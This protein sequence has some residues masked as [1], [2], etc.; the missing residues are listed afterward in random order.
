MRET[1]TKIMGENWRT[2]GAV[3]PK[4][5]MR[6]TVK[7]TDSDG[8][9]R[10]RLHHTDVVTIRANGDV[11]LDSGGWKTP[12][13]KERINACVPGLIRVFQN[14]GLWFVTKEGQS[15]IPFFDGMTIKKGKLPKVKIDASKKE[16]ALRK[17]IKKYAARIHKL[18][19]VPEPDSGDC[20]LCLMET[21]KGQT[22]GESGGIES[23]REHLKRHIEEGYLHGSIIL[24]AM[25]AVGNTDIGIALYWRQ[26][27]QEGS[28]NWGRQAMARALRR[29]LYQKFGLVR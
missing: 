27:N 10:Y 24:R 6:N 1:M 17:A 20:W 29:Y 14:K 19:T 4:F 7:W 22:M 18:E 23:E 11:V 12:T 25:R 21:K 28:N 16:E 3:K 26:A 8:A 9:T 5:V 2:L 15:V 13:T